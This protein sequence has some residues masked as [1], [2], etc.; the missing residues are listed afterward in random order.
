MLGSGQS[1]AILLPVELLVPIFE[2]VLDINTYFRPD[3]LTSGDW[4]TVYNLFRGDAEYIFALY[5]YRRQRL[6]LVCRKW[7]QIVTNEI[8]YWQT[9]A[10]IQDWDDGSYIS[11]P[12]HLSSTSL[13]LHF[14]YSTDPPTLYKYNSCTGEDLRSAIRDNV[15]RLSLLYIIDADFV[16]RWLATMEVVFP[17]LDVLSMEASELPLLRELDQLFPYLTILSIKHSAA[18]YDCPE[19]FTISLLHLHILHFPQDPV[20]HV[21]WS[22][23]SLRHLEFTGTEDI[24]HFTFTEAVAS[25]TKDT[26]CL[27]SV[28]FERFPSLDA[29]D[30][31]PLFPTIL[32]LGLSY[33]DLFN[34]WPPLP[35]PPSHPLEALVL[36]REHYTIDHNHLEE[37]E[38]AIEQWPE[39]E[40]DLMIHF[41]C[42][43]VRDGAVQDLCV[44]YEDSSFLWTFERCGRPLY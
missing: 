24:H 40:D 3:R 17:R 39:L 41:L 33:S 13:R 4:S 11:T 15:Q 5:R 8:P 44:W 1:S 42:D 29:D 32:E 37:I 25:I 20:F 21:D 2:T 19:T 12:S 35:P 9:L 10:Y 43:G 27:R 7:N 6:R 22:L 26:L 31:W 34:G 28:G 23:P 18:Q 14:F 30:F 16:H 36:L 38:S